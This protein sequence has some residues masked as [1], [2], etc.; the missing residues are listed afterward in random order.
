M[1]EA[2]EEALEEEE[3]EE[4]EAESGSTSGPSDK[5]TEDARASRFR[6]GSCRGSTCGR[7]DARIRLKKCC[8]VHLSRCPVHTCVAETKMERLNVQSRVAAV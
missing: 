8:C 7:R 1:E 4:E 6:A 3:E 5:P 2:L